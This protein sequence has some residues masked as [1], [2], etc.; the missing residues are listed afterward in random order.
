MKNCD[1]ASVSELLN[2]GA[3]PGVPGGGGDSVLH[4][5]VKQRSTECLERLLKF[6]KTEDLNIYN[7]LGMLLYS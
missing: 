5:A 6:S 7:D 2:A 3:R 4:T 1:R